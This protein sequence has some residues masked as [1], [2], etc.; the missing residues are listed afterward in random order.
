MNNSHLL[1]KVC[2]MTSAD[3]IRQVEVLGIDLMGFIFYPRSPRFLPQPPAYLPRCARR[4][5]VFVN[6]SADEVLARVKQFGLHL[7]QLHGNE[8]PRFCHTLRQTD[9]QV[10]KAFSIASQDDIKATEAYASCCDYFLFDTPTPSHGGS[11]RCFDWKLLHHYRGEVPFL[12]SGGVSLDGLDA[13]H[14]L[15]HPRLAGVDLNSRFETAPGMKDVARLYRFIEEVKRIPS[16]EFIGPFPSQ[17][18]SFH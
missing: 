18:E 16:S 2:G 5:G 8:S 9:V 14:T 15:H 7:V 13:L 1:I 3:N 4:V 6:A 17:F 11:G 10:I 12:L